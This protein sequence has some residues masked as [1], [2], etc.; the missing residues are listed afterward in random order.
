MTFL[1]HFST[2]KIEIADPIVMHMTDQQVYDLQSLIGEVG[3]TLGLMLG[4]SFLSFVQFIL[5]LIRRL[6]TLN[7][8]E[9]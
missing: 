5:W 1:T 2:I 3:G 9:K 6:V 4:L 8:L 7:H